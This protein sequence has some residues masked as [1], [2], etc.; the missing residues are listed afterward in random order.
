MTG[1]GL[2]KLDSVAK[3]LG[4]GSITDCEALAK[5]FHSSMLPFPYL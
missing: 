1:E 2:L 4:L 5:L 3:V